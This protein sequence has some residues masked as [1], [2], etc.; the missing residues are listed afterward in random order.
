MT[1]DY[2]PYDSVVRENQEAIE[3]DER[4]EQERHQDQ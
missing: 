1:E 2:N 3:E 4:E